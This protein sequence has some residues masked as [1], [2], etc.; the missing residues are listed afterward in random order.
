MRQFIHVRWFVRLVTIALVLS[1]L[2]EKQR[3]KR[4]GRYIW[5]VAAF[6]CK[7]IIL[8]KC[9]QGDLNP[10]RSLE[11]AV[12]WTR[13]DDRGVST[14]VFYHRRIDAAKLNRLNYAYSSTES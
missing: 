4:K 2:E 7:R 14:R 13:L 1:D 11:R 10:C 3:T 8:A 9:P 12:S 6:L 5:A